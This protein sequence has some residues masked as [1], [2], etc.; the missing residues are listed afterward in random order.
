[1]ALKYKV[2]PTSILLFFIFCLINN[3]NMRKPIVI[4]HR[5]DSRNALENSQDAIRRALSIPVDMIEVDVRRSRDN[6]LYLMHDKS[7]G[8]TCDRDISIESSL[9]ADV[10][11]IRLK[12]GER[13]PA[14]REVLDTVQTRAS[15][16]L[17]IKSE[18]AGALAAAEIVGSGYDG[19]VVFTSFLDREVVDARRIMPGALAGEIFDTF[20]MSNL[21]GYRSKG[22]GLISLK[23]KTVTRQL[24]E[25]CH[26]RRIRV[27]V[28]TV[29]DEEDMER[30]LEWGVDGIYSNDPFT[31]KKVVG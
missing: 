29:D 7:T 2:P 21:P 8:R 30:F 4:A 16:N 27:F 20:S 18:G 12:N 15:L 23:H 17:E 28:W 25:A 9:G 1:M 11:A 19:E 22:Y 31:L 3:S 26:E 6:Q 13:I 14:L 5:G 10:S 24:V